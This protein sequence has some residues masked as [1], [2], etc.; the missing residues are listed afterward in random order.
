M[1]RRCC[2]FDRRA[3]GRRTRSETHRT[4][5]ES[6]Y[7][8]SGF[9]GC[10][11]YGK[12]KIRRHS[13]GNVH[14]VFGTVVGAI[15]SPMIL[16]KEA[17][18]TSGMHRDFMYALPEL[19]IFV[20]HEHGADAAGFAQSRYV[21]H[22]WSG[23]RRRRRWPRTCAGCR[24]GRAEWCA[25]PDLHFP[26]SSGDDADDRTG[27]AP[28]TRFRLRRGFRKARP[29]LRRN[30]AR[31]VPRAGRALSA[32]CSSR[33]RRYRREIEWGLAADW[34]SSFRNRRWTQQGAPITLRRSPYAVLA[35]AAIIGHRVNTVP[36]EIGTAN[37][38]TAAL[39]VRAKDECS[40]GCS[41]Q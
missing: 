33:K 32:R 17:L 27:P 7:T 38:P 29:A 40:F 9:L 11:S 12:T 18:R 37:L 25:M 6:I 39:S 20:G 35:R 10:T 13:V 2:G 4:P 14:P 24:R 8:Q 15:Q 28:A 34:S 26:A 30:K 23:K 36:V 5:L 41:H 1:M 22:R 16:Q 3:A 21:R 31:W 19:G